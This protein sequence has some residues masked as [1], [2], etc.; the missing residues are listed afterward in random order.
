MPTY[1]DRFV[2][3]EPADPAEPALEAHGVVT[4]HGGLVGQ[5]TDRAAQ[6]DADPGARLLVATDDLR[7]AL[8]DTLLVPLVVSGSAVLVRNEMRERRDARLASERAQ[9]AEP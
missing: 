7:T 1:P 2:P 3:Y 8:L 4:T 5:A 6:L 9:A